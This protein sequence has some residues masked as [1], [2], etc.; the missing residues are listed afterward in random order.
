[1]VSYKK[2]CVSQ[3]FLKEKVGGQKRGGK[4]TVKVNKKKKGTANRIKLGRG[5]AQFDGVKVTTRYPA[6][7]FPA[8][9]TEKNSHQ[10][11][12]TKVATV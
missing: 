12:K 5:D 11:K 2:Q 3:Q 9:E 7:N 4:K 6:W 1:L 8:G 10:K